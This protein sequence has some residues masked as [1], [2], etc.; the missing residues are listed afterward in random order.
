MKVIADLCDNGNYEGAKKTIRETLKSL[1]DINADKY[2]NE[3]IPIIEQLKEYL[4]S[5]DLAIKNL[6]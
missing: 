5:L 6:K 4:V 2:S 3:L 1:K